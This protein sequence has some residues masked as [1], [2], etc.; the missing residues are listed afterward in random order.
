MLIPSRGRRVHLRQLT[1]IRN[2]PILF[3][4]AATLSTIPERMTDTASVEAM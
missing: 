2:L 4:N 3:S 1:R